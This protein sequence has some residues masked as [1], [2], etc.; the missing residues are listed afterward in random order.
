MKT[1]WSR[2][3]CVAA[4]GLLFAMAGIGNAQGGGR[5]GSQNGVTQQ[6]PTGQPTQQPTLPGMGTTTTDD[7]GPR[8]GHLEV[9]QEKARNN[10]RQKKLIEDTERLLALANELKLDVD[11]TNKDTLS[12]D[13]IKKADEIEKLAHS[14]KEK[15][16]GT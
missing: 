8:M 6:S 7:S 3:A 15:M 14:V 10:D 9:E 12:L 1:A 5:S 2:A 13:V 16:K 4:V 11:K